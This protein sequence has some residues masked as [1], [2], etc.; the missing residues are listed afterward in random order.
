MK[1]PVSFRTSRAMADKRIL[2]DSGA[3]DNF[4]DPR[5]LKRLKLGSRRLDRPRKIWNIDGTNN[6][7][8]LLTDYVELE[9]QT[10]K[11]TANMEF[12]VTDLGME[13]MILGYPWLAQFEPQF[14]WKDAAIDTAYL[15]IVVRSLDWRGLRIRPELMARPNSSQDTLI[16]DL[17]NDSTD[18]LVE[19]ITRINRICTEVLSDAEKDQIVSELQQ[20]CSTSANISTKLAQDVGQY[21][22]E[23]PIP[24]EYQRH[25][26]VFS[27][28]AAQRFPPSRPWDHAIE[29]KEGAPK[30]IDC[31]IYPITAGEDEK[32]R[33]FIEEQRAKGYIRPSKSPYASPFFFVKKKDGKLR[34]VQ[35]YR[36]L[37]EYTIKDKYP[38]PLIPD[39]IAEV[40]DAWIFSK[41]NI[42]WGYN[43]V[44]IKEGD[45]HK[46]AF[47]TKYGLFEPLVMYFGLTNS[48]ATFQAMM[49]HL[50]YPLQQKWR[51]RNVRILGYMDDVLIATSGKREHHTEA[52]H[53]F[54]DM[55]EAN[56]L[57]LKPEKCVW[58]S[59]R[60]DYLGLILEKGVTRMDPA[61]VK[62]V[63]DW[64]VPKSVT[65]VH[66]FMGFCNFYRPFIPK[67]SHTAKS[68][69]NL[70]KKGVPFVWD[71]ECQKAYEMLKRRVTEEP[72]LAQ[73]QLDKQFEIEV[74]AS[75]Y[76]IGAVLLQRGE[77]KK[78]HPIAYYSA[79]L[80]EAERNYDIYD[81]EFLA[82]SRATEHWRQFIAGSPHKIIIWTDHANLQYWRQPQKINRCLARALQRFSEY[83]VELH[84]IPGKN[85]GRADALSRRP[86]YD[87][88][89]HDNENITVLPDHLFIRMGQSL[90]YIPEEPA[91][92]DKNI[93]R[94]W[95]DPHN[96]KKINGEWWKG[97]RKVITMRL[98]QRRNII[99]AYHDLPAY[100][101]P[102]IS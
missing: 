40:Q 73:P 17:G 71:E 30:A 43:N 8:G 5:L 12:L 16:G 79:T 24:P 9:V 44:R 49:N 3:T 70:T 74:D 41:F 61:K 13:D 1:I 29:L 45:E 98:E 83:D 47:K 34:P 50:L 6:K 56:D 96:L 21:T 25:A 68:L 33:E 62:G 82:I 7:A 10:G 77:D 93:L 14:S 102:G 23:V 27:E 52:T 88:G 100:G 75:G 59:P 19:P 37:N 20:E 87:Q 26:K 46:A 58:D 99:R 42:R 90:S 28:T 63:A 53:K 94:P 84:H 35:D 89:T 60:I 54:L 80:S 57:Y 31:K 65:E 15:P 11:K 78:R 101:H 85:N 76:A 69:N 67:Y 22:K 18:T 55:L 39:L 64:P 36:R 86:D 72:V 95:I 2:V 91:Q 66:S 81:L 97:R 32:L 51:L 48:P 92:Q 38:L 4:I